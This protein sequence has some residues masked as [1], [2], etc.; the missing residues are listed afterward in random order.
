MNHRIDKL[1]SLLNADESQ[2]N[3]EISIKRENVM[4]EADDN[5]PC[6]SKIKAIYSNIKVNQS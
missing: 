6:S 3:G 1:S 4:N 2:V 5:N